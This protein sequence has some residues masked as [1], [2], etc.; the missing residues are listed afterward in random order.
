MLLQF[1]C[2]NHSVF[3]NEAILD[4]SVTSEKNFSNTLLDTD[5]VKA[6]PLIEIHGANAS[7]KTTI[8]EAISFM[9]NLII[10]SN[11]FDVNDDLPFLSFYFF[12]KKQKKKIVN[13][14]FV[15]FLMVLNIDMV[16]V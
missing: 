15:L 8:L 2:K 12:V 6:L 4:L 9:F 10:Y 7:G 5:G 11:K 16:L 1:K 13:M 3:Y 14:R